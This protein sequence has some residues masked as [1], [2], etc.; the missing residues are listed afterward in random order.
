MGVRWYKRIGPFTISRRGIRL[1]VGP[2]SI[3][4]D[5]NHYVSGS[6][7][8]TGLSWRER[9]PPRPDKEER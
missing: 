1:K 3:G 6:L 9:I 7:P 4:T 2:L 8:G 5:G